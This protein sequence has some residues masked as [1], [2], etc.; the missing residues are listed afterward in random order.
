[1]NE[2]GFTSC[3][4]DSDVWMRK[5]TTNEGT[6]YWEF[7]LLYVDDILCVSHRG[8]EV[9][10]EEIG[11]HFIVKESSIGPPDIYLGGKVRKRTI[12]TTEGPIEAW[13]L[14]PLNTFGKLYMTTNLI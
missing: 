2:L 6:D 14:I 8:E 5:A 13:S 7:V 11:N 9:L 12:D 1:M 4:A 10:R 3:K